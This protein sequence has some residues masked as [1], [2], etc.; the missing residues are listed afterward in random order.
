MCGV[1]VLVHVHTCACGSQ[2]LGAFLKC[3]GFSSEIPLLSMSGLFQLDWLA[4]S[5][6]LGSC[7][8]R[9]TKEFFPVTAFPAVISQDRYCRVSQGH[10]PSFS[11]CLGMRVSHALFLKGPVRADSRAG[12]TDL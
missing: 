6:A 5:S 4:S 10:L 7:H 12:M 2:E 11:Q 1:C 9:Y 8:L 3:T